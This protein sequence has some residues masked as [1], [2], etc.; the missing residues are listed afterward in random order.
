MPKI[1]ELIKG[2][3]IKLVV[4][5]YQVSKIWKRRARTLKKIREEEETKEVGKKKEGE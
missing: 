3:E 4:Y 1:V 5:K 2:E